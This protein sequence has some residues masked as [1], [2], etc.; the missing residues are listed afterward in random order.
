MELDGLLPTVTLTFDLLIWKPKQYLP[1]PRYTCDLILVKFATT[2]TKILHS[3]GF[4]DHRLLWPWPLTWKP[5]LYDS[6][7]GY[8]CDLILVKLAPIV[9]KRLYVPGF[10]GHCLLWP[11]PFNS[12]I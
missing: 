3:C 12:K 6:W 7:P 4:L 10:P 9:T 5:N 2:V 8:I 1:K 11:W